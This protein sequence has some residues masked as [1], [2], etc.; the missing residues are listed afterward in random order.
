M[1]QD[2]VSGYNLLLMGMALG[3]AVGI[4]LGPLLGLGEPHWKALR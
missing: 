1:R 2:Y 4:L 3:C